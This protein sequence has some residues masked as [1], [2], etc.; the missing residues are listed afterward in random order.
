MEINYERGALPAEENSFTIVMDLNEDVK[1]LLH[2][3]A[4]QAGTTGR[5]KNRPP[6]IGRGPIF[7]SAARIVAPVPFASGSMT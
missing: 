1:A 5:I 2:P 4:V 3:W 6:P 7:H